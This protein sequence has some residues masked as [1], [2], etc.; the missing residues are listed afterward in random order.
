MTTSNN[1]YSS[2][3]LNGEK[4]IL[5]PGSR[6]SKNELKFRLKEMDIKDNN[7]QDKEY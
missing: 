3:N 7:S 1:E 6:F 5:L 2:F 4:I